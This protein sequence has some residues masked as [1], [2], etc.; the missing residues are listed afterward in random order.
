MF[1]RAVCVAASL[2]LLV[3]CSS[4]GSSGK[5]PASGQFTTETS[6]TTEAKSEY[7]VEKEWAEAHGVTVDTTKTVVIAK[8]YGADR[9][10]EAYEDVFVVLRPDGKVVRFTGT[11][12]PAQMPD[13]SSDTVPD[14]DHDGRKDLGIVRPGVYVAHGNTVY[15]INGFNRAAFKVT[16]EDDDSELAAW[17]DLDGDGVFSDSE[18]S[19]AVERNYR[20]S[21]IYI[22]YGF[23][24]NG[25]KI[26]ADEYIG[27]WSVGCMNIKFLELDDFIGAVGGGDVTFKYAVVRAD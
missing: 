26:G 5:A 24:M 14:V 13:P 2:A 23:E 27:P 11:T 25:T 19:L 20:I 6:A 21:G 4:S 15:G 22:H 3:G 17:R 9:R 1:S 8:R 12:K 18:K 16:T 10:S 7:A